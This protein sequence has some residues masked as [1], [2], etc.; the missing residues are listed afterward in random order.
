MSGPKM[1][2]AYTARVGVGQAVAYMTALT[3]CV[4]LG[5]VDNTEGRGGGVLLVWC[6]EGRYMCVEAIHKCPAGMLNLGQQIPS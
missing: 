1:L 2:V 4:P 3:E 5:S 6:E